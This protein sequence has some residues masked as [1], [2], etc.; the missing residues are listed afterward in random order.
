MV[1]VLKLCEHCYGGN[2]V[3]YLTLNLS[4]ELVTRDFSRTGD[5]AVLGYDG[6]S[7]GNRFLMFYLQGFRGLRKIFLE[8][9]DPWRYRHC[10]PL[11]CWEPITQ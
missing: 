4:Y 9:L 11:K 7:L 10:V 3:F 6:A 8:P 1:C 2:I 5:S